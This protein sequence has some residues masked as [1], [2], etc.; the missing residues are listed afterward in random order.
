MRKK[1]IIYYNDAR[2]Y[3]LF[4][5]E[6]PMRLQEA[7]VP[8]AEVAG[9]AHKELAAEKVQID[10]EAEQQ[11]AVRAPPPPPGP[12]APTL[13]FCAMGHHVALVAALAASLSAAGRGR[14]PARRTSR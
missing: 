14:R 9:T 5:F 12:A 6:P 1:R 8:V 11:K 3:Y 7:W 2:H 4:V 10:R 13:P